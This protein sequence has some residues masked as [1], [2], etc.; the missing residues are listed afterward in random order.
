MRFMRMV[1]VLAVVT[2]WCFAI[3]AGERKSKARCK[4]ECAV[5]VALA[6]SA[7]PA[8]TEKKAPPVKPTV[9][10]TITPASQ[11]VTSS[12]GCSGGSCSLP[13]RYSRRGR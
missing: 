10:E 2:L 13:T 12:G 6:Q 7:E 8:A 4:G 1:V 11:T 3:E 5:A 9:A